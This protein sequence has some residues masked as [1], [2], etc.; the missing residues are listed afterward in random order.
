MKQSKFRKDFRRFRPV[1]SYSDLK[2]E[3]YTLLPFNFERLPSGKEIII[4]MVGDF[5]IAP[6]GTVDK[7]VNQNLEGVEKEFIK[8][9]VANSIIHESESI[10]NL[11]VLANRYRTVKKYVEGHTKLHIFV[12]SLRCEHTCQYCQVSRVSTN[13]DKFDLHKEN[14]IKGIELMLACP[15]DHLTMEFQ[16][17]EALLAFDNIQFA[18]KYTDE[19]A[20]DLGK[21]MQYVVCT[22][23]ALLDLD[24]LKY[25]KDHNVLISASLDG[26][27]F[28][29]NFNRKRPEKNSH[30]LAE[31][32]IKLVQKNWGQ[33]FI[34]V[35][36][37]TS[38]ESL[39]YPIEI[40]DEYRRLGFNSIF[41]RPISPY[42]F[43]VYNK[44]SHYLTEDFL[45]FY[46]VGLN[47]ILDLNRKGER[48]TE[49]Y[50]CI[51]LKRILTA[52]SEG[53]VDL[54]SPTGLVNNVIVYDY[55]GR[56]FASDEARML[57]QMKD[58]KFLIGT[59]DNSW[60]ELMKAPILDEIAQN[61][62]NDYL[63]GC[64]SCALNIYCG[65]DPVHHYATQSDSYGFRPNSSFCKRNK[66]VMGILFEI[67]DTDSE[68]A[69][70]FKSWV[71]NG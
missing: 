58:D 8:D 50:T 65:S 35:L 2:D 57:A 23:L 38:T 5:L 18:I 34:S 20:K 15:D 29:H 21:T 63:A 41:L 10:K 67:M 30:E 55:D 64:E 1:D 33:D 56:I 69:E 22:N 70:I 66:G 32:G 31:K 42:G 17:G 28:V 47:Y 68:A 54:M 3:T 36:M 44:R 6:E 39:K 62:I 45:E 14:L 13:K 59:V 4:S 26:P 16:G 71:R 60:D 19:R 49:T 52:F 7:I 9:L 12:I 40:I 24:I 51:L 61:G 11:E 37:T 46:K 25:C 43:A 27:D 53:Y 48:F